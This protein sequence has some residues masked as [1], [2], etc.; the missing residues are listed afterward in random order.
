MKR[1]SKEHDPA[2]RSW[3]RIIRTAAIFL[4][5][6]FELEQSIPRREPDLG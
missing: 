5:I 3:D 4:L 2:D 1:V 6:R